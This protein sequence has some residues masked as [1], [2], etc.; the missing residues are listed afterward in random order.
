MPLIGGVEQVF[1]NEREAKLLD[2]RFSD[3]ADE[4][5]FDL[6]SA[7]PG[8]MDGTVVR[9]FRYD[10]ANGVITITDDIRCDTP[11]TMEFP[12]LTDGKIEP[13]AA[14]GKWTITVKDK[15]LS[16]KVAF[17]GEQGWTPKIE[18]I[19]RPAEKCPVYRLAVVMDGKVSA[20]KFVTT[21][22]VK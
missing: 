1:G 19:E 18:T 21:F 9:T 6:S 5:T 11:Q 16:V 7:Y 3:G 20:A 17:E 15:V 14:K 2:K 22:S 10:R 4:V 13:G 12:I 8:F